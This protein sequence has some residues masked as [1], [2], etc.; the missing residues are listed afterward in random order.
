MTPN[1]DGK[2]DV[3]DLSLLANW[4][5]CD[6]T[7]CDPGNRCGDLNGDGDVNLNDFSIL[8]KNWHNKCEE[9]ESILDEFFES[10]GPAESAVRAYFDY[11][12][13]VSDS[14]TAAPAYGTWFV[15]ADQIFTP[16]VMTNGRTLITNAQSAAAGDPVAER[17]VNFLEEGFTNAE[18]TL[19]AQK[20]WENY[21]NFGSS[22]LTAWQSAY[23]DLMNYRASVEG[24]FICN[25]GRLYDCESQIW[26]H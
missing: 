4:W 8:A 24:D 14:T 11:W 18:K 12:E 7:A 3:E 15:G 20:A 13:N 5:L 9:V 1:G 17:L 23:Q 6:A 25:M 22:Y 10:F 19:A 26:K 2:N 21:Q 16:S